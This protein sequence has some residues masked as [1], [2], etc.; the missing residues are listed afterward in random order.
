[1]AGP[2]EINTRVEVTFS[3]VGTFENI[4]IDYRIAGGPWKKETITSN[5]LRFDTN[6]I[7]LLEV[8]AAPLNGFSLGKR[9]S[10]SQVIYGTSLPP[11]DVPYLHI[12]GDALTWGVVP[13]VDLA[14]YQIR[15]QT[16]NSRSWGDAQPIHQGLIVGNSHTMIVRPPG[17]ISLL[18]KAFDMGGRESVNVAYV[19]TDLGNPLVAN[20]IVTRDFHALEFP[21]DVS[22]ATIESGTGDLIANIDA[23]PLLWSND[24][25]N[26]WSVDDDSEIWQDYTYSAISFTG[27]FSTDA[28]DAGA[29][30]TLPVEFTAGV[31]STNYRKE[32]PTEIWTGDANL[33]WS[34]DDDDMWKVEPWLPWP[35][36]VVAE[37]TI[38]EWQLSAA[39]GTRHVQPRISALSAQL[40]VPDIVE[41]FSDVAVPVGGVRLPITKSYRRIVN[42]SLTLQSDG[43]DAQNVKFFDRSETLGPL[44]KCLDGAEAS[45]SGLI[46]ATIQ[47]Y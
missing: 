27:S 2:G 25:A 5:T 20:V 39:A 30:L 31:F 37:Q 13:D 3:V 41:R 42:I 7:G 19:V 12:N 43:G 11:A 16:G 38:Y 6:V 22:G 21:G 1:M 28:A 18:I 10:G 36:A 26:V 23:E 14:G 47:G 15:W 44:V 46:D 8:T 9:F 24:E 17:A 34:D 32:S 35:G 33:L 4:Y 45:T 40:D 29:Q